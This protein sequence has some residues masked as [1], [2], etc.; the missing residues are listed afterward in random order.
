MNIEI[1]RKFTV[2]KIPNN[3]TQSILI[4]QFYML[5]DD[6]F[7]QRLRLFDDKEAIIQLFKSDSSELKDIIRDDYFKI[8]SKEMNERELFNYSPFK[9][10]ISLELSSKKKDD[11]LSKGDT[12]Y[13]EIKNKFS[14][15]DITNVG[16]IKSR[17]K[18]IYKIYLKYRDS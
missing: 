10:L 14:F 6:N 12:L 17:G 2:S 8:I 13:N 3:I 15:C 9:R 18:I 16:L 1:E 7:V 11:I 5:I 4:E